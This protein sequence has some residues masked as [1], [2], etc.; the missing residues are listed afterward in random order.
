MVP[1]AST[2]P[3]Y[4]REATAQPAALSMQVGWFSK[5]YIK[6]MVSLVLTMAIDIDMRKVGF[7]YSNFV[8]V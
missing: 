8:L 6:G 1:S 3:R 2:V 5:V 4:F 7:S